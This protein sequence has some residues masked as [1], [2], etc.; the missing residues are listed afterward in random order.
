MPDT[1]SAPPPP[2]VL[3]PGLYLLSGPVDPAPGV[4]VDVDQNQTL[5]RIR[6]CD[7]KTEQ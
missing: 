6:V 1:D 3:G 5:H 7:L 2:H 4:G